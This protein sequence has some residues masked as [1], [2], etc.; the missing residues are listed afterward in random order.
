MKY[1]C[2]GYYDEKAWGALSE[3]ERNTF[4][5]DC[6]AYDDVLRKGRHM[7]GG[8]ALQSAQSARTVR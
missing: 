8:E 5:D 6:F 1:M 4:M 7:I 3:A 2:L